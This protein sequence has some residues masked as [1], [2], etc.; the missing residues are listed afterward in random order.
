MTE[1]DQPREVPRPR[2]RW[3]PA[4]LALLL[5]LLLVAGGTWL[6]L[7]RIAEQIV[8]HQLR[9]RG[10]EPDG[11][12]VAG[13]GLG[14]A[15]VTDIS[16][17]D[18]QVHLNSLHLSWSLEDLRRQR[19]AAI[20]AAGL[21]LQARLDGNGLSFGPLDAL[22]QDETEEEEEGGGWQ[23][24]QIILEDAVLQL[25]TPLG[26]RHLPF[27]ARGSLD[28]AISVEAEAILTDLLRETSLAA[29]TPT[30]LQAQA[31]LE[32]GEGWGRLTVN[33]P[34][35]A[36]DL[37]AEHG[38]GAW[39]LTAPEALRIALSDIPDILLARLP[40]TLHEGLAG[41][42]EVTISGVALTAR[43]QENWWHVE[44]SGQIR[45]RINQ[46]RLVA[47]L[48]GAAEVLDDLIPRRILSLDGDLALLNLP[49]PEAQV[50]A[51]LALRGFAGSP[52]VAEGAATLTVTALN[53]ASPRL[54]ARA[55]ELQAPGRLRLDGFSLQMVLDQP[56]LLRTSNLLIPEIFRAA[57]RIDLRLRPSPRPLIEV[58]YVAG[59]GVVLSS[60]IDADPADLQ[61]RYLGGVERPLQ[62]N[63]GRL[64][65]RAEWEPGQDRLTQ[66]LRM[67]DA[68]LALPEQNVE[69]AGITLHMPAL[70]HADFAVAALRLTQEPAP[71]APLAVHGTMRPDGQRLAFEGRAA[72]GPLALNVKGWHDTATNQGR[73][74]ITMPPLD[75]GPGNQPGRFF[76][77]LADHLRETTGSL[78]AKGA[79]T[80]QGGTLRP[81]VDLL[82]RD[83]SGQLGGVPVHL[84]NSVIT[85]NNLAPLSTLPDQAA[86]VA[87]V[88][89]GL[90][91]TE[92]EILFRVENGNWLIHQAR[93]NLAGGSVSIG[94]TLFDP[95]ARTHGVTLDVSGLDLARLAE[96][97]EMEGLTA[98]GTL[99]GSIPVAIQDAQVIISDG[100]LRSNGPGILRYRPSEPP[101]GLAAGG[102]SVDLMLQALDNFHYRDLYMTLNG[103]A[104]EEMLATLHLA[105]ANPDLFGGYP[106]EFNLNVS[107]KLDTILGEALT[108]YRIPDRIQERMSDF[109]IAP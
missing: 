100:I 77:I 6:F 50:D 57:S 46:T 26:E 66:E 59:G 27:A 20:R 64:H 102:G 67:A 76:P 101:P 48:S 60:D 30:L 69:L 80:W 85:F 7:P 5:L 108:G 31:S 15:H 34:T 47:D 63:T 29:K 86:A 38:D 92:G 107:G 45:G 44:G 82:L 54:S 99:T 8:L 55:M 19:L 103:R 49:L 84:L 79:M 23:V 51:T 43:P 56:G 81:R 22:R 11:L 18:G 74:D 4:L 41:D 106:V 40:E 21:R 33:G 83:L 37:L 12:T 1:P 24:G 91:L 14:G 78:S 35:L 53:V 16:V 65:L 96:M 58:S 70:D 39:H 62:G 88:E 25:D 17:G 98:T 75:L 52:P 97:I 109:G 13:I 89:A 2:R 95:A 87:L 104:G 90:P 105:G 71:L 93:L 94:E 9:E 73:A 3:F 72:N 42:A 32:N 68:R 61:G 36:L 28:G 10:L